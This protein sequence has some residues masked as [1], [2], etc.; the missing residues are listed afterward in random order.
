M[1]S[2][3]FTFQISPYDVEKL[4]PQA[5]KALEKRTELLSRERYPALWKH[6]D[7]S[8]AASQQS[9][10]NRRRTKGL[11]VLCLA[12]G[13]FLFV[14]GLVKPQEL[15]VPLL[16]GACAIGAGIGGLWRSRKHRKNPFDRSAKLLLAGK[17][18]LSEEDAVTVIFSE[19]GMLLPTEE[20][21]SECVPY[22]TFACVIETADLFLLVY[23]TRVTVLQKIDLMDGSTSDFCAFLAKQVEN[24]H[25]LT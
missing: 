3:R 14:P 15:L 4:L 19:A 20:A 6:V 2:I 9:P 17:D 7:P 11:S 24:Y 10:E 13:I 12:L 21:S 5:S 22:D 25:S 16:V 18:S 8:R 1:E 23:D